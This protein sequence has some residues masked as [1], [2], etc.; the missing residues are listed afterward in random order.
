MPHEGHPCAVS[1]LSFLDFEEDVI[2]NQLRPTV[3]AMPEDLTDDE[4][5]VQIT[6]HMYT[7]TYGMLLE[8][9]ERC[10]Q[11]G[12]CH[13]NVEE[14]AVVGGIIINQGEGTE[15]KEQN[16]EDYFLPKIF[17]VWTKPEGGWTEAN[18]ATPPVDLSSSAFGKE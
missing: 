11:S 16:R 14:I 4:R 12:G 2:L 6:E 10:W 3:E 15:D 8:E 1:R 17:H 7:I 9:L 13:E 5:F 18:V